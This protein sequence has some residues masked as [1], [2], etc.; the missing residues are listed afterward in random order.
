L[1][2]PAVLGAVKAEPYSPCSPCSSRHSPRLRVAARGSV[3]WS[4]S[5]TSL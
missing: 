4:P 1:K 2:R 3:R 5:A